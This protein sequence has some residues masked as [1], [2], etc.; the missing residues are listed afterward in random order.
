MFKFNFSQ[1]NDEE[2]KEKSSVLTP[3]AA[4]NLKY[5]PAERVYFQDEDYDKISEKLLESTLNVFMS[6][7]DYEISYLVLDAIDLSGDAQKAEASH[8]DLVPGI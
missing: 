3:N 8:S 7:G 6:E 1:E 4:E 5:Y 2:S